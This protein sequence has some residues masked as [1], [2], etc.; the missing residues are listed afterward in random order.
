MNS[1][2][3]NKFRDYL[4][5]EAVGE[6]LE[7]GWQD[8]EF[9][10]YG[11]AYLNKED[12]IVYYKVSEKLDN[13]LDFISCAIK[14]N[15][16]PSNIDS[17]SV[18]RAVPN[19]MRESVAQEIKKQLA[20]K[21]YSDYP[22]EFFY[23]LYELAEHSRSNL[24]GPFLWEIADANVGLFDKTELK[25]FSSLIDYCFSC[26][27]LEKNEYEKL[28]EWILQENENILAECEIPKTYVKDLYGFSYKENGKIKCIT[29]S[30]QSF[31]YLK[32]QGLE[33]EGYKV[34]PFFEKKYWFNQ[35]EE[36]S[37]INDDF[38]MKVATYCDM[39]YIKMLTGESKSFNEQYLLNIE[40]RYGANAKSTM[41]RY[42]CHWALTVECY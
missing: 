16:F 30:L 19:G 37:A 40:E 15:I 8:T 36:I 38:K 35:Q 26:C 25:F 27:K 11:C 23:H 13:L 1:I 20:N 10:M 22:K 4:V 9:I 14:Q 21:L 28:S 18:T 41:K 24:A 39:N 17:I 32:A 12:D 6:Q 42:L 7:L 31:L 3:K 5:A 33:S 2:K 29:N 34:S